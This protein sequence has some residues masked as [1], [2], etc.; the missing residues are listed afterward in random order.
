MSEQYYKA[1]ETA[2]KEFINMLSRDF[3]VRVPDL[4][5]LTIRDI[6]RLGLLATVSFYRAYLERIYLY[7]GISPDAVLEIVLH[8][9]AHHLQNVSGRTFDES[10]FD[11]PHC[12]RSFEHEAKD[13]ASK[14]FKTYEGIW[15]DIAR[16]HRL[17]ELWRSLVGS[18]EV[19]HR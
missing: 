3:N 10:E 6:E 19:T 14:Y 5:L 7:R 17:E 1:Y 16:K 4:K 2:V 8:E 15:N 12:E 13:F 9:F 11:K 18:R